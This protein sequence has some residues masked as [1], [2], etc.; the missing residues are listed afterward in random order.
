MLRFAHKD[1]SK[2]WPAWNKYRNL[3]REQHK[4]GTQI[5]LWHEVFEISNA[6]SIYHNMQRKPKIHCIK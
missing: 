1:G 6:E 4:L 3:Q 5:G 2:H